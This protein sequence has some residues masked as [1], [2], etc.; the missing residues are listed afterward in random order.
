MHYRFGTLVLLLCTTLTYGQGDDLSSLPPP[1]FEECVYQPEYF[2][3]IDFAVVRPRLKQPGDND[4]GTF[5]QKLDWTVSPR[6]EYGL[7][8]RGMFN[9][10]VGYRGLYSD[11]TDLAY[12]PV[13]DTNYA[14]FSSA[15]L[16][17]IDFGVLSE[18]FA[19]L[20]MIRAQWDLSVRLTVGDF[21]NRADFDFIV[22]EPSYF[23]SRIRQQFVGAGP[24]AGLRT[25]L[26]FRDTGLSLAAQADVGIE[27]GSY[28]A[29]ATLES[30]IDGEPGYEE[31]R[32][33]KGG[34]LWHTSAQL[35][36]RYAP[37]QFSE[38]LSF[39]C[40]YL[41]EAWF[42][43]D[44]NLMGDSSFGRFDYH[45]PFFRMEWRY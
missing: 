34:I 43:K 3:S 41:Y 37:P 18:P 33:S 19:L 24:R 1:L 14:L 5:S 30:M 22:T 17:A 31:E 28:R 12:E 13:L 39:T 44:I 15:E 26:P 7:M 25:Y 27:W 10:Y 23:I 21:Y 4:V 16:H 38:R 9:P 6:F 45:G 11:A 29:K 2:F 32:I 20:S 36:L 8:N 42:S 35:G 40:G